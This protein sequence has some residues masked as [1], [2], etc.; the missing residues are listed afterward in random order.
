M[1]PDDSSGLG[2]DFLSPSLLTPTKPG[3]LDNYSCSKD[4][5]EGCLEVTLSK[6]REKFSTFSPLRI[7]STAPV[8]N[9]DVIPINSIRCQNVTIRKKNKKNFL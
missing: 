8:E 5:T 1:I 3:L 2:H 9:K 6:N 4:V 7:Y